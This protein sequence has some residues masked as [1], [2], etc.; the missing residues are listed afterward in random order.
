MNANREIIYHLISQ[1]PVSQRLYS[2]VHLRVSFIIPLL[3]MRV[4]RFLALG[5]SASKCQR[6]LDL[7]NGLLALCIKFLSPLW[8]VKLC[9]TQCL[10]TF[11]LAH[12]P[13]APSLL[14]PQ[15]SLPT[16]NISLQFSHTCKTEVGCLVSCGQTVMTLYTKK[17][18]LGRCFVDKKCK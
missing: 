8:A 5:L 4:L 10:S 9:R 2:H 1:C 6:K 11:P 13:Q 15:I 3:Q 17:T 12:Q 14:T 7:H 16:A 18:Y